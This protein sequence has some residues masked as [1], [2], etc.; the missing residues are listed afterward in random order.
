MESLVFDINVA[1]KGGLMEANAPK[2]QSR[3]INSRQDVDNLYKSVKED[4]AEF[5]HTVH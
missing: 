4:M 3:R 1:L 2:R 5:E